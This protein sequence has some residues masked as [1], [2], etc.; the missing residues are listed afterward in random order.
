MSGAVRN[1]GALLE[2]CEAAIALPEGLSGLA[3]G[4]RTMATPA[5]LI[6]P[7]KG[8]CLGAGFKSHG[9]HPEFGAGGAD[10]LRTK[11]PAA[12]RRLEFSRKAPHPPPSRL[13][14]PLARQKASIAVGT[15]CPLR[16]RPSLRG[17]DPKRHVAPS[18]PGPGAARRLPK[19]FRKLPSSVR[20]FKKASKR[21]FIDFK[22]FQFLSQNRG[23]SMAYGRIEGKK[24]PAAPL[25]GQGRAPPWR[26][27]ARPANRLF[28]SS[29]SIPILAFHNP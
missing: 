6:P 11:P 1:R 9:P 20:G 16:R 3:V 28:P 21:P 23:L 14:A 19:S 24:S 25:G 17:A 15:R 10:P 27:L 12:G 18:L 7:E 29:P 2:P 5:Q 22:K 8:S 26:A 13:K 4:P